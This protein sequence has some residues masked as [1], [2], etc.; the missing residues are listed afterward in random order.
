MGVDGGTIFAQSVGGQGLREDQ[1]LLFGSIVAGTGIYY[2][3]AVF[4]QY[5]AD[6]D[7]VRLEMLVRYSIHSTLIDQG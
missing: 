4:D 3:A 2:S 1:A 6:V 5:L 7:D